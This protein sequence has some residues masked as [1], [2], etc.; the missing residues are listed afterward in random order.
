[1]II[2]ISRGFE[3]RVPNNG[4]SDDVYKRIVKSY[5]LSKA[6]QAIAAPHYQVGNEWIPIFEEHLKEFIKVMSSADMAQVKRIFTNFFREKVS[7]GLHGLHFKMVEKYMTEGRKSEEQ[8]LKLYMDSI[9]S[10]LNIFI[11]NFPRTDISVLKRNNY[12]NPYGYHVGDLFLI[13]GA[14]YHY[15]CATKIKMLLNTLANCRIMELGGGFGGMA[16]Y[17]LRDYPESRYLGFDL[18]E[19][20]ALQAYYLLSSFPEKRICL[21]GEAELNE[22]SINRYDA[23]L[24]PNFMLECLAEDSVNLSFNSY[25]LAEMEV[26]AISNYIK[27]ICSAT[28]GFFYHLNHAVIARVSADLFPIDYDKFELQFRYPAMW[29]KFDGRNPVLDEHEYIYK[30]IL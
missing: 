9:I 25:S 26:D 27:L 23:L 20:A 15:Y 1:M 2:N 19:Q 10:N 6:D 12:G 30:R 7:A 8:D 24:M 17:I 4:I 21:Y 5:Q 18:P 16:Y 28:S 13:A 3:N 14:E 29:G 22:D 11:R